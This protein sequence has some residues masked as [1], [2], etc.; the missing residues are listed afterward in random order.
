MQ[1]KSNVVEMPSRRVKQKVARSRNPAGRKKDSSYGRKES[2]YLSPSQVEDLI[3]AAKDRRHGKRDA[4]MISMA[5][6]HVAILVQ[7][8]NTS[9]AL[10]AIKGLWD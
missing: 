8:R 6:H 9:K 10:Q 1:G 4:L 2:K 7:R 5:Y 3:K